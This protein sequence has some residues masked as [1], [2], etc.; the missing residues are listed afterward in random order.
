MFD[1]FIAIINKDL[2]IKKKVDLLDAISVFY[3]FY[4]LLI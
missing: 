4:Y 2:N 3:C 1:Q